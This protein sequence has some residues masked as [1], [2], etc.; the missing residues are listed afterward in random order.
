MT[1]QDYRHAW[2]LNHPARKAYEDLQIERLEAE[3]REIPSSELE[4]VPLVD[5]PEDT[6]LENAEAE[7]DVVQVLID[8]IG[9]ALAALLVLCA[10]ALGVVT[11]WR[12]VVYGV[13]GAAAVVLIGLTAGIAYFF[14]R[15]AARAT[16][17]GC[18]NDVEDSV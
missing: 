16:G 14:T 3:L 7:D 11:L 8:V 12:L 4:P 5:E 2:N 6:E 1:T 13:G 18:G 15:G 17:S 10:V 9:L